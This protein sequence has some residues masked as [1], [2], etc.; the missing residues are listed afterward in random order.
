VSVAARATGKRR[1]RVR[2]IG[3]LRRFLEGTGAF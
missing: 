2:N 1:I 3:G